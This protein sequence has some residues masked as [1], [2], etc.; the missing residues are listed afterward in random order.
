M[1]QK[2]ELNNNGGNHIVN[3]M[4]G[5]IS[6]V[7]KEKTETKQIKFDFD[8]LRVQTQVEQKRERTRNTMDSLD[9]EVVRVADFNDDADAIKENGMHNMLGKRI[10][11]PIS[12]SPINVFIL[13]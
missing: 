10:K 3:G 9:Y 4:Y 12:Y 5:G 11:V 2:V 1:M 6:K 13:L 7:R 8:N